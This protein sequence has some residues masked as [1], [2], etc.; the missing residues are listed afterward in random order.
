MKKSRV[1]GYVAVLA[2]GS[3]SR[4]RPG[5]VRSAASEAKLDNGIGTPA[6]LENP[7]CDPHTGHIRFPSAA[8]PPC[9]DAVEASKNGGNTSRGVTRDS[10]RW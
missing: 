5:A 9:V 4:P 7:K 3:L 10:I 6:A 2:L 8:R 1:V